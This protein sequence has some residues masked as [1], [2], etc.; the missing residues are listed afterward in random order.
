MTVIFQHLPEEDNNF[1]EVMSWMAN[2]DHG[3][4]RWVNAGLVTH[5]VPS[6]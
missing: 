1:I 5:I 2:V 3:T 4:V 6:D